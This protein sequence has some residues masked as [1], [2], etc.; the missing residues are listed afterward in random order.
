MGLGVAV[1]A[2]VAQCFGCVSVGLGLI[3][4]SKSSFKG[5]SIGVGAQ[6]RFLGLV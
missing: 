3:V 5:F 6:Y 1:A 2:L 4:S